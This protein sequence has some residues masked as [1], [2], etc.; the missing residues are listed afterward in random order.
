MNTTKLWTVEKTIVETTTV[1]VQGDTMEDVL[2]A[3]S[4]AKNTYDMSDYD[5][6]IHTE[7]KQIKIT[8]ANPHVQK[9]T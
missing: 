5:P 4:N 3:V 1:F 9:N 7:D 8:L 6:E 2:A